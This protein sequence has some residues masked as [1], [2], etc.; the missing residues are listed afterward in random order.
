M[1]KSRVRARAEKTSAIHELA[2][3]I[4]AAEIDARNDVA[5]RPVT[6]GAG[7][8]EGALAIKQVGRGFVLR[9][10]RARCE[11]C[12]PRRQERRGEP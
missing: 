12:H 5:V 8:L 6:I 11:K 2:Q 10:R 4:A 3:R 1:A 7:V 9:R